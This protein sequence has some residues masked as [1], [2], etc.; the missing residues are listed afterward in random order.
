MAQTASTSLALA[1]PSEHRARVH[2]PTPVGA[3]LFCALT[4]RGIEDWLRLHHNLRVA[5]LI[6]KVLVFVLVLLL[7]EWLFERVARSIDVD[8]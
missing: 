5:S 2:A 6:S 1:R 4:G 7:R 3:L 8:A